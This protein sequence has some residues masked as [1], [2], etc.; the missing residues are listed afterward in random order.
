MYDLAIAIAELA[1]KETSSYY[2]CCG[3]SIIC[4]GCV[5]SFWVS[6][7]TG[8]CPYCNLTEAAPKQLKRSTK[9]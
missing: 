5:H 7:N 6:G 9:K 2:A 8:M 1:N 4:K 3:K